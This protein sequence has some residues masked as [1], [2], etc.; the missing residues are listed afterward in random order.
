VVVRI[1]R[2][3]TENSTKDILGNIMVKL[4][5]LG[6]EAEIQGDI[7]IIRYK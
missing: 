7:V 1:D 3:P 6:L 5:S 2:E 4:S